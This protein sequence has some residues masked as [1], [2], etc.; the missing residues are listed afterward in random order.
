[1]ARHIDLKEAVEVVKN[2]SIA[3]VKSTKMSAEETIRFNAVFASIIASL[4]KL[5]KADVVEVVRC[6]DCVDYI[7]D[8]ELDHE[9]LPN[10]LEADGYC[11]NWLKYT[12]ETNFCSSGR[13]T[14]NDL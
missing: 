13:R 7:P 2:H 8:A 9:Q 6:K 4:R 12:D 1:M 5:P 11:D 10:D 3:C 14:D